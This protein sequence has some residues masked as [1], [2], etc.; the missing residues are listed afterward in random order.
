MWKFTFFLFF[1]LFTLTSC[2]S[3]NWQSPKTDKIS[4]KIE[5]QESYKLEQASGAVYATKKIL[6]K[7]PNKDVYTQSAKKTNDLASKALPYPTIENQ[8]VWE[9]IAYNLIEENEKGQ[10]Q[11]ERIEG[12]LSDSE[13]K[14]TNLQDEL[15]Q[16][17]QDKLALYKQ[18]QREYKAK[19]QDLLRNQGLQKYLV[20]IFAYASVA[21][22][23]ASVVLAYFFGFKI[24]INGI[25][26]GAGFGLAAYLVTQTFFAYL[27]AGF[28]IIMFAGIIYYIWGRSQPE[29][30]LKKVVKTVDK[31]EKSP[32][33][34]KRDAAKMMKQQM[35]E[36]STGTK[37]EEKEKKYIK[38][39]KK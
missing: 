24:A 22:V 35:E 37:E 4:S 9:E 6:S 38:D 33:A 23:L 13:K 32:D 18:K 29:K 19:I 21:S 10:R 12:K 39:L 3:L 1:L 30:T 8:N 7:S 16:A 15:E 28:A 14:I 34:R 11:V 31:M 17:Q 25:I 26:A 5:K 36:G 27:A 20:K 2:N